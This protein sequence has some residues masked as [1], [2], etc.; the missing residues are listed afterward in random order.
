M[1]NNLVQVKQHHFQQERY[2]KYLPT[3]KDREGVVTLWS[4]AV[5]SFDENVKK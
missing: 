2:K 1:V 4:S 5:K 3:C